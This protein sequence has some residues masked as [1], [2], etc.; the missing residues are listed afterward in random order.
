MLCRPLIL[1]PPSP[2]PGVSLITHLAERISRREEPV[3]PPLSPGS[4]QEQTGN[5]LLH[6]RQRRQ[7]RDQG[8]ARPPRRSVSPARRWRGAG[9]PYPPCRTG[10]RPVGKPASYGAG[11]GGLTSTRRPNPRHSPKEL[12]PSPPPGWQSHGRP[13]QTPSPRMM[14]RMFRL[15]QFPGLPPH[16]SKVLDLI[17]PPLLSPL[18]LAPRKGWRHPVGVTGHGGSGQLR[19]A[20]GGEER[21]VQ[22]EPATGER[23]WPIHQSTLDP[24]GEASGPG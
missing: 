6:R 12:P 2:H 24:T 11:N 23:G 1:P 17:G 18:P 14:G 22:Q 13:P 19:P 20:A 15:G 9:S 3:Q 10:G 4:G 16:P 7:S 8:P 21:M 5:V